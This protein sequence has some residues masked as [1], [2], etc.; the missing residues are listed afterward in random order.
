MPI[1]NYTTTVPAENSITE[2]QRILKCHD[3]KSI[4]VDYNGQEPVGLAFLIPTRQGD[5]PFQLPANIDAIKKVLER[6]HVKTVIDRPR[7]VRVAWRI[8][9]DWVRAQMAIIETEMVS[10][11][12]VFL[13]YMLV[14][15]GQSLFHVMERKGYMLTE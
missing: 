11:E 13:P 10:L 9:R 1:A 2:I 8:L 15:D 5:L 14:K 12:E 3:V 6:Q 4:R 7:A